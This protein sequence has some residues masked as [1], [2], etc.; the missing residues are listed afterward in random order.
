VKFHRTG[1]R[2]CTTRRGSPHSRLRGDGAP[3]RHGAAHPR[4]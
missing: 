4:I 3:R 2:L 1:Q